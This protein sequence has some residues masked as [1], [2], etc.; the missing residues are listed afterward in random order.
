MILNITE[1]GLSA[2]MEA[3]AACFSESLGEFTHNAEKEIVRQLYLLCPSM[4]KQYSHLPS[5]K[6]LIHEYQE[7]HPA[8]PSDQAT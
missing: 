3:F 8:H 1:E 4:V 7:K 6:E 2:I 5:V